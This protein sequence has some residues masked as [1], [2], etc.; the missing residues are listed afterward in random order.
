MTLVSIP[1]GN[2]ALLFHSD[3]DLPFGVSS[4]DIPKRFRNLT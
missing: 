1:P 3:N 2:L 4:S